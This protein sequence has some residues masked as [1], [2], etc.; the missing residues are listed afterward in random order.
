M[1]VTKEDKARVVKEYGAGEK[2][3]GS[4]QVQIALLTERIVDLT[5]HFKTHKKDTNSRR[6]LLML[7]GQRRRL[8]KYLQRSDLMK[9]RELLEKLNIRK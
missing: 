6:G 4:T 3:T 5:E 1:A 9:Y 2:N 8:L 7:V